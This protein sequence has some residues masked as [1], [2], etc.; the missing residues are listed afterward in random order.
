MIPK[1]ANKLYRQISEELGITEDLVDNFIEHYYKEIRYLMVNLK[2]PRINVEGLGH[3][4]VKEQLVK[5]HIPKFKKQLSDH[6]TSTF[7]AYHNKKGLELKL[8][9]LIAL[10][11]K[12]NLEKDRKDNFKKN[13][14]ESSTKDN[15][16]E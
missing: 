10:E 4:M 13:K 15:L 7:A 5:V 8:D 11:E 9:Q 2:Y 14:D 6:D 1:K 3:F 12:I 16:G